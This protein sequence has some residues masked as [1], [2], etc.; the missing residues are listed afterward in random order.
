MTSHSGTAGTV[1]PSGDHAGAGE[2]PAEQRRKAVVSSF[3]GNFVEWFDYG[4]YSYLAVTIAAAFFPGDTENSLFMTFALFAV[5]FLIRPFG[6]F[7][8]GHWGDKFGRTKTLAWSILLMTGATFLIGC[9]PGASTIGMA[10]PILLLVFR[11]IQGFS[12]AGEYAGA[13]ALLSEFAPRGKRGRFA[14]IVPAS[15]ASGLLLGS[16]S[17]T[18]LYGLLDESSMESWGWRLPF[19]VAGPLGLVGLYIRR[20][21]DDTPAFQAH[22]TRQMAIVERGQ[23]PPSPTLQLVTKNLPE[24]IQGFGIVLLNAVGFYVVLTFMPTYL[25]ENLGYDATASQLATTISLVT[26]ISF[27]FLTGRIADRI[28]RRSTL[29]LAS[30]T[31]LV[32]SVPAFLVMGT[33]HYW[34][35]VLV[36]VVMGAFL[37]LNDG[38]LPSA[39]SELYPTA[40][41]FSGFALV[42][43]IGNALFGGPMSALNTWLISATGNTLWPAYI[44]MAAALLALIAVLW[45]KDRSRTEIDDVAPTAGD[46]EG[47][48]GPAEESAPSGR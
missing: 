4:A 48:P 9:L 30:A 25:S 18:L 13:S 35:A 37:S 12:A 32:L 33:G 38:A 16:L 14:A 45:S 22:T 10:A 36:L 27:I 40:V 7:F 31:F 17:A 20:K 2:A 5:S 29:I 3:L 15:T 41:R 42:F 23:K 19:L 24:L 44:L 34:L 43:N 46:A 6:A 11:L 47:R 26:Y 1:D 39:V 21:I 8:W 28:G